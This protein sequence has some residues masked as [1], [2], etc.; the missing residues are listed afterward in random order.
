MMSEMLGRWRRTYSIEWLEPP[1]QQLSDAE[2]VVYFYART[3]PQ[4][5]S[6]GIFRV[7]TATAV[8][9]IGNLTA[10]EFDARLDRVCAAFGWRFDPPSRVLWIPE[11]LNEN[12][13]QSPNVCR[14]WEKLLAN[15]PNCELKYEA[16]EAILAALKD[17]PE[18]FRNALPKDY[19]K[20]FLASKTQPKTQTKPHQGAG[21]QGSFRDSGSKRAGARSARGSEEKGKKATEPKNGNGAIPT[22]LK[23]LI[24]ETLKD[25]IGPGVTDLDELV[26]S[27]QWVCRQANPQVTYLKADIVAGLNAALA[28][29]SAP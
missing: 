16:A 5:T 7:S 12:P 15:L 23:N 3:G 29:R 13:A 2:K 10:V 24:Q 27:V 20:A 11:W 9:D 25:Y 4:S 17:Y 6:V 19:L 1:F 18:R 8:E 21:D 26:D 22:S 14:A 28:E